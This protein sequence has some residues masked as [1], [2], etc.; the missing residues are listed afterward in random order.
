MV[1][2]NDFGNVQ[3]STVCTYMVSVRFAAKVLERFESCFETEPRR[4]LD[5]KAAANLT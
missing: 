1:I 4:H 5:K 2:D 3:V